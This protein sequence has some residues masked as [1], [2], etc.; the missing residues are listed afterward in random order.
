MRSGYDPLG[1]SPMAHLG[2]N[3]MKNHENDGNIVG[4]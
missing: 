3:M 1:T 2:R 4:I